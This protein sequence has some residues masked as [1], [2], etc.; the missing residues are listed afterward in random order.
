MPSPRPN[1]SCSPDEPQTLP[2]GNAKV[3]QPKPAMGARESTPELPFID[4]E[5][6][7]S[8]EEFTHLR[9]IFDEI[10]HEW[11]EMVR[12]IQEQKRRLGTEDFMAVV[13]SARREDLC[14]APLGPE[15]VLDLDSSDSPYKEEEKEVRFT[16]E[17][18][19]GVEVENI[20]DPLQEGTEESGWGES[21]TIHDKL[22]QLLQL[23]KEAMAARTTEEGPRR[24][25]TGP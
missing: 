21:G 22:N 11:T 9:T 5:T 8:P 4:A 13:Q 14:G 18:L 24:G 7:L 10:S 19:V 6:D 20:E 12:L 1:P 23:L 25:E 15:P 2:P 17:A 3:S 16:E